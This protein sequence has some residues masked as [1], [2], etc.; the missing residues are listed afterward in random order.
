MAKVLEALASGH[1]I[2]LG[3]RIACDRNLEPAGLQVW[4][5]PSTQADWDLGTAQERVRYFNQC[6]TLGGVFGFLSTQLFRREAWLSVPLPLGP[7]TGR[8]YPH[9]YRLLA[10]AQTSLRLCLLNFPLVLG[11]GPDLDTATPDFRRMTQDLDSML[12]VAT[13]LGY[14]RNRVVWDAFFGVLRR[15]KIR[16]RSAQNVLVSGVV[17]ITK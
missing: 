9:I 3:P 15:K 6:K 12:E 1:D 4:H 11:R 2:Y 17:K 10:F 13:A 8:L 14:R 7:L 16:V 5:T